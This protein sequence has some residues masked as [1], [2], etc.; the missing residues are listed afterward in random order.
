MKTNLLFVLAATATMIVG[1]AKNDNDADTSSKGIAVSVL[2]SSD[3]RTSLGEQTGTYYKYT[4]DNND[5]IGLYM[6]Q[7]SQNKLSNLQLVNSA[8]TS[9]TSASFNGTLSSAQAAAIALGSY[10]DYVAYYPYGGA[11]VNNDAT[12]SFTLP[13][14]YNLSSNTFGA[15]YDFM[16]ATADGKS[17]IAVNDPSVPLELAFKHVFAFLE[18]PITSN[19]LS[20]GVTSISITAPEG[21]NIAGTC[22]VDPSTAEV[23]S[24]AS[25]TNAITVNISEGMAQSDKVWIPIIPGQISGNINILLTNSVGATWSVSKPGTTFSRSKI[26]KVSGIT[27]QFKVLALGQVS[28]SIT[29]N[30]SGMTDTQ[31]ISAAASLEGIDASEVVSAVFRYQIV[32]GTVYTAAASASGS[33]LSAN[34]TGLAAGQYLVSAYVTTSDDQYTSASTVV[35][36][37]GPVSVSMGSV[38][39]SYTN[40]SNSLDGSTIYTSANTVNMSSAYYSHISEAG[41]YVDG[42][43]QTASVSNGSF[44]KGNL[45][46]SWAAHT[47]QAYAVVAGTEYKSASTTVYVTGIPQTV[48]LTGA[49]P[50]GW[51]GSSL[52]WDQSNGVRLNTGSSSV[53]NNGYLIT[54]GYY[55]PAS[56]NVSVTLSVRIYKATIS[57]T[58]YNV[59]VNP[60]SGAVSSSTSNGVTKKSTNNIDA[61]SGFSD[62]AYNGLT[63]TSSNSH[64]SINHNVSYGISHMAVKTYTI[65]YR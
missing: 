45:S 52:S 26:Y 40:K 33:S 53:T 39:T 1:C 37:L 12:V 27:P 57:T 7:N 54:P 8:E 43:K 29:N 34:I 36:V 21:Y 49:Q 31:T 18:I 48:S 38:T 13:T 35:D 25:G 22:T 59:Y 10:Y 24:V 55:L 42:A 9:S 30:V 14:T 64:L 15:V 19:N 47:V 2:A 23:N 4:W 28:T 11:T 65:Q 50:S 32:G 6:Y 20:Y 41:L 44:N 62:L 17:T 46:A 5:G 58:N 60:T 16:V 63:L 51:G 61:S 56:T 3:T